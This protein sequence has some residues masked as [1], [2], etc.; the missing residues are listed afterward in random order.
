MKPTKQKKNFNTKRDKA[1]RNYIFFSH[2]TT[3]KLVKKNRILIIEFAVLC[4][5]CIN[6]DSRYVLFDVCFKLF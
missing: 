5:D 4:L 6:S 3:V 1:C 2:S